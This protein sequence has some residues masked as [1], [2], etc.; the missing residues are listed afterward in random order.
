MVG[1][2]FGKVDDYFLF[3]RKFVLEK[4]NKKYIR[5]RRGKGRKVVFE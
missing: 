4:R 3:I 1:V 2:G 5:S